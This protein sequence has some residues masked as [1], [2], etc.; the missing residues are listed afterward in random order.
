MSSNHSPG[1]KIQLPADPLNVCAFCEQPRRNRTRGWSR[2]TDATGTLRGW[3]CAECPEYL[4][5]IKRATDR[6]GQTVYRW[7]AQY[8]PPGT[9]KRLDR[10]GTAPTLQAA[11]TE[12]AGALAALAGGRTTPAREMTVQWITDRWV[13][14]REAEVEAGEIRVNTLNGYKSSLASLLDQIGTEDAATLTPARI[15]QALR[16][17]ITHGGL[18]GKPAKQRTINYALGTLR[19]VYDHAMREEWVTRNPAALAKSPRA[20]KHD[21]E[22]QVTRWAPAELL[23]FRAYADG[24]T[25]DDTEPWIPV[26]MRLSLCGPRRSEVLGLDWKWVDLDRGTFLVRQSRVKT[27]RGNET[28]IGPP[29]SDASRRAVHMDAI[30]SGTSGMLRALWLR[31]G[32]PDSGLVILDNAG[33]PVTPDAYSARWRRLCNASG[34]PL[35]SSIHRIRHSIATALMDAGVPE[36]QAAALLGHDAETFRRHYVQTDDDAAAAGAVALGK[37]FSA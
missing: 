10:T 8:T 26:A 34:V 19:Q 17:H 12:L 18:R 14:G 5:P 23:E 29:K 11:R 9:R 33:E 24:W 35:L 30:H 31:Q 37:V 1:L 28:V 7:R 20:T 4:E 21:D 3:S 25:N 2:I 13:E 6:H 27:G 36:H 32:R 16:H 22:G 15:E